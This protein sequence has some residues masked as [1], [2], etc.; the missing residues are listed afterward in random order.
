MRV[1]YTYCTNRRKSSLK[2][3]RDSVF[4]M[5][6]TRTLRSNLET[7]LQDLDAQQLTTTP[8]HL[9]FIADFE[10]F[11]LSVVGENIRMEK[12]SQVRASFTIRY[13]C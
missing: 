11:S 12:R 3:G 1:L 9:L 7:E 10:A 5:M 6:L 2:S 4:G 8:G 13:A